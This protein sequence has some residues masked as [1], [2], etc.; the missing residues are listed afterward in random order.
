MRE[1][2]GGA[3]LRVRR[4]RLHGHD[5]GVDPRS[6][7]H[8]QTQT[9]ARQPLPGVIQVLRLLELPPVFPPQW[10]PCLGLS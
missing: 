8:P 7:S 9:S 10:R 5:D 1:G 2:G 3:C 6:H 4:S